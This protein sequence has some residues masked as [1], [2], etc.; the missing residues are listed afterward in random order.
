MDAKSVDSIPKISF[1]DLI[2]TSVNYRKFTAVFVVYIQLCSLKDLEATGLGIPE[3]QRREG[4]ERSDI[5][6]FRM[7]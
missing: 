7:V 1:H 6:I 3:L 4:V 2:M 5:L